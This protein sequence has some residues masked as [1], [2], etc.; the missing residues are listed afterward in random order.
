VFLLCFCPLSREG[1]SGLHSTPSNYS[2]S[3]GSQPKMKWKR[4]PRHPVGVGKKS[5]DVDLVSREGGPVYLLLVELNKCPVSREPVGPF[6]DCDGLHVEDAANDA[7]LRVRPEPGNLVVELVQGVDHPGRLLHLTLDLQAPRGVGRVLTVDGL[8][9]TLDRL[10][11][12]GDGLSEVADGG[13]HGICC[14]LVA[15]GA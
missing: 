1:N 14:I 3:N 6:G 9:Q 4:K 11:P 2:S 7:L 12:H 13:H 15:H 10:L 5:T 8:A